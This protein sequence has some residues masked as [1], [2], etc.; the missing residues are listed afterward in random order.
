ML[1]PQVVSVTQ[2][3]DPGVS[4]KGIDAN[5]GTRPRL[6]ADFFKLV[7]IIMDS[8]LAIFSF[9]IGR[10]IE[11]ALTGG[12]QNYT[13]HAIALDVMVLS[14]ALYLNEMYSFWQQR[15][16]AE[17]ITT[18][19]RS[20]GLAMIVLAPP[21]AV[22]PWL[23]DSWLLVVVIGVQS[24]LLLIWRSVLERRLISQLG[25]QRVLIIGSGARALRIREALR[26]RGS[27][28]FELVGCTVDR[29]K[30]D[31][32]ASCRLVG[33]T[34]EVGD[35]VK[36]ENID[37]VV[38]AQDNPRNV[39]PVDALLSLKRNGVA[40]S[41]CEYFYERLMGKLMTDYVRPSVMIF[42]A[43]PMHHTVQ[44]A[45]KN[46]IDF[47]VASVLLILTLPIT[48]ITAAIIKLSSK[49]PIFYSQE[50]VGMGGKSFTI[51]KFR[52]MRTDAEKDGAKW[53]TQNDSR[54]TRIGKFIRMTR[55]DEL[56]QLVNVLKGEMSM[57][58]P[59]PERPLFVKKLRA[60]IPYYDMRHIMRPGLSGWAQVRYKYG[61]S[62]EDSHEKLRY[63]LYYIKN[64]TLF[65]DL[66]ILI[67]TTKVV[68]FGSGAR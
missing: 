47:T 40:V 25:R 12:Q 27:V 26:N 57:V 3:T 63:D 19:V 66:T 15:R 54:V 44:I 50:R 1:N 32:S 55:I 38:V 58:G 29:V 28:I 53:A 22:F 5:Y 4:G 2:V 46:V 7:P 41:E 35:L 10:R 39:F 14:T 20:Q 68:I 62:V 64:Y 9:E 34:T 51:Y 11:N 13:W 65:L 16:S 18:I 23:I 33:A 6:G 37:H 56:P 8:L 67:E 36:R 52:S 24:V 43:S 59:R 30:D 60:E 42:T 49:G 48:L 45:A 61:S 21:L 31:S 17:L